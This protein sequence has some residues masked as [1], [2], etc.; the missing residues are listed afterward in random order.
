MRDLLRRLRLNRLA[1]IAN[2]LSGCLVCCV[3][4]LIYLSDYMAHDTSL[5]IA[6]LFVGAVLLLVFGFACI[7]L[8][9]GTAAR[10]A[11]T[12]PCD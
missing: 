9:I 5:I 2:L 11:A 1:I 7:M 4:V 10:R 12:A 8:E 3:I 6:G